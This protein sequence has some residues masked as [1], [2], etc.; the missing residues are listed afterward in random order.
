[1]GTLP[2]LVTDATVL[3]EKTLPVGRGTPDV[4]RA[5]RRLDADRD[6]GQNA[7][8]FR[9]RGNMA[10]GL[11][12]VIREEL[13]LAART[14]KLLVLFSLYLAGALLGALV[15]TNMISTIREQALGMLQSEYA[16][17]GLG[18]PDTDAFVEI[19]DQQMQ[20]AV[21]NVTEFTGADPEEIHGVFRRG[22]P[23]AIFFVIA[24]WTLPLMT[25]IASFDLFSSD[26]RL[27]TFCY[28]TL[29]HRRGH[30]FAGRLIAQV[31]VLTAANMIAGLA[32]VLPAATQLSTMGVL[33]SLRGAVY[34]S[35]L[36]APFSFAFVAMAAAC[37][38]LTRRPAVAL[39]LGVT[40]MM[41]LVVLR[42]LG[43]SL[44]NLSDTMM[45]AASLSWLTPGVMSRWL[46][47]ASALQVLGGIA[48][49]TAF[50]AVFTA[51]AW[52]RFRAED[53]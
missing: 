13:T 24:L 42:M 8:D 52:F 17:R 45:P 2:R 29:R 6:R 41:G 28:S 12:F 19:M 14:R 38:T 15:V 53:L 1:M 27:R 10:Q 26:L 48:M 50:G 11:A 43:A 33:A 7:P 20:D 4:N 16:E 25:L 22:L 3:C 34:A 44:P 30:I 37:S 35:L 49:L 51:V 39:A 46:W 47:S 18:E 32:F 21:D 36:L 23:V 31:L 5:R 40:C 9:T